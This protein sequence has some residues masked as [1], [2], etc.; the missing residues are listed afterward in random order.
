[1]PRRK[2]A[3]Y[4]F[5]TPSLKSYSARMSGSR[6]ARGAGRELREVFFFIGPAFAPRRQTGADEANALASFQVNYDEQARQETARDE[7]EPRLGDGV[8]GFG[9]RD[10]QRVAEGGGRLLEADAVLAMVRGGLDR[11]PLEREPHSGNLRS[12]GAWRIGLTRSGS[13]A[14]AAA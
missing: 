12:A 6:R 1:M 14:G 3:A 11:V 13:A 7:D 10:G 8:V 5:R 4:L 2:R 9:D